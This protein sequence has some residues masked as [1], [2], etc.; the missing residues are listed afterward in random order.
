MWPSLS[1]AWRRAGVAGPLLTDGVGVRAGA[2]SQGRV[3]GLL[4]AAKVGMRDWEG[5]RQ[6]S[7]RD[8][9][10]SVRTAPGSRTSTRAADRL[11]SAKEGRGPR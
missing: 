9:V 1:M 10:V 11:L 8:V 7:H 5:L 2:P 4:L 6:E 3:H